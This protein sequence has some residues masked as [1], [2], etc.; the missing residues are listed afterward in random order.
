MSD[1]FRDYSFGGWLRSFR[2]KREWTLRTVSKKV[3]MDAGNY[4]KLETSRLPP[5]RSRK[6]LLALVAPLELVDTEIEMLLSSAFN[7]HLGQLRRAWDEPEPNRAGRGC[8][9]IGD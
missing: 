4:S 3:G 6:K 7:Y 9:T 8:G 5:P 1:I 2:I